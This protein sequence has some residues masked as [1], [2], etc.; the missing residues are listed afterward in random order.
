MPKRSIPDILVSVRALTSIPTVS[1]TRVPE[2]TTTDLR[3]KRVDESFSKS[4]AF[5]SQRAYQ[6][7]LQRFLNWTEQSWAEITPRQVALFKRHLMQSDPETGN[8]ILSDATVNRTLGTLKNFYGWLFRSQYVS[9][10]QQKWIDKTE[11]SRQPK[12]KT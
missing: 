6:Q 5:K 1:P 3:S 11:K 7:D 9:R 10:P 2:R 4:L 8:R 12:I